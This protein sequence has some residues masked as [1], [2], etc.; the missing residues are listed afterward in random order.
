[1]SSPNS[2]VLVQ[3]QNNIEPIKQNEA[4]ALMTI[5][6]RISLLP[7]MDLDRVERL[8]AMHQQMLARSAE[9]QF[10]EAM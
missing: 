4:G 8:F 10:N 9:Q 6:E 7:D 1:M 2:A 5:I 3:A